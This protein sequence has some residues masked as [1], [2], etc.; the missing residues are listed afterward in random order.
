MKRVFRRPSPA[1]VVAI[2]ALIV[3]LGG[4]AIGA[5]FVTKKQSKKIAKNQINK[6]APGLS[7]ASAKKADSAANAEDVLW[8]IVNDP[9]GGG[10]ATVFAA[11]QSGTTLIDDV[12][13]AVHFPRNVQNCAWNA[14]KGLVPGVSGASPAGWAQVNG[15]SDPNA[16]E[17]RTRDSGGT[18]T[19]A[20]FHLVVTC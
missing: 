5:A 7:V 10:N 14:T 16:V 1:M 13:V 15:T 8:A 18:I 17:V 2:V 20:D 4:T 3:A 9:A 11:G 6:L 19:D 12:G